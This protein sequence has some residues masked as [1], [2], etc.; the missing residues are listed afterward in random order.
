MLTGH[1]PQCSANPAIVYQTCS[2]CHP[3][4]ALELQSMAVAGVLRRLDSCPQPPGVWKSLEINVLCQ[5]YPENIMHIIIRKEKQIWPGRKPS[6]RNLLR[7]G[8]IEKCKRT[9][10]HSGVAWEV[11]H[12]PVPLS[13][14]LQTIN[15]FRLKK[16]RFP[17]RVSLPVSHPCS[18][19]RLH[20][21]SIYTA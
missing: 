21:R 12:E 2:L 10:H 15:D 3:W 6:S 1:A 20:M 5:A 19:R 13:G 16:S 11:V 14:D 17:L 4:P 8:S 9:C 18:S 7:E